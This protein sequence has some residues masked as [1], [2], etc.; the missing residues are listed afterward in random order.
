MQR[1]ISFR[2]DGGPNSGLGHLVRCLA[3]A[4]MIYPSQEIHF[5]CTEIPL[6]IAED[7]LS[8]GFGF[9]RIQSENE[10]LNTLN[11]S[12]TVVLD[13][14]GL[15]TD[16]QQLVKNSGSKLVCIDDLGGQF[17]FADVII[18]HAPGV[19]PT[20]YD[21]QPHTYYALGPDFALLRPSFLKNANLFKS[22]KHLNKVFI[23]LGGADYNNLTAQIVSGVVECNIFKKVIVVTGAAFQQLESLTSLLKEN[24]VEHHHEVAE[25]KMALLMA[26]SDIAIVPASGII[27]EA[28]ASGCIVVSSYYV[29]NQEAIFE[30]FKK[31][32]AAYFL[33]NF[34][35]VNEN[36]LSDLVKNYTPKSDVRLIDGQSG[37][38]LKELFNNIK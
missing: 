30:G 2:V 1:S 34:N 16:F 36:F 38:R 26:N 13:H 23:C 6:S 10:F 28:I 7:M 17:F 35:D 8:L 24:V 19:L 22:R 18:N 9:T 20:F 3:L 37:K 4:Q 21:A 14:Y 33:D 29:K 12:T 11:E 31:L 25:E 32:N 5:Y 15:G 27:F